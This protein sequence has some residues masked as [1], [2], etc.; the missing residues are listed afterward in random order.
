MN[1]DRLRTYLNE[2]Q[3]A[4]DEIIVFLGQTTREDFLRD[5]LKQR[6]VGMSLL[7]I[8]EAS[9]RLA[10]E[11]P[12][13]VVDHPEVPWVKIRGMR[14]RIAHGYLSINLDTVWDTSK[15]AIPVLL[16]QLRLLENWH[17]QGE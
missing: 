4:A 11:Y 5:V 16:E 9:V 8:G 2:M 10:E 17:A 13:F 14:N 1:S 3:Q 12:E 6:A 7:I 15:S